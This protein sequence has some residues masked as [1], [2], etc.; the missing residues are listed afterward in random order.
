MLHN[1]PR[2]TRDVDDG[3]ARFGEAAYLNWWQNVA[4]GQVAL[5][6]NHID[7]LN[8]MEY[9]KFHFLSDERSAVQAWIGAA[10]KFT[11]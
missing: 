9:G 1:L 5:S 11:F 4:R 7:D 8:F 2:A 6:L 10:R 3:N